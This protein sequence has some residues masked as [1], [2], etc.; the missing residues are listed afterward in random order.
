MSDAPRPRPEPERRAS[1]RVLIVEDDLDIRETL[2]EVLASAGY[3]TAQAANG[4]EGLVA[5]R[6]APPDLIVLDLMMP[7]MD[8]WQF[9]SVQ[10]RDPALAEIPLIVISASGPSSSIDADTYLQKPFPLDRLVSEA[11]R[12]R[13]S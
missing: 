7:V 9:R 1:P 3:E 4:L 8:G 10:R 2:A 13:R 11:A 6:R 5:A 12:L